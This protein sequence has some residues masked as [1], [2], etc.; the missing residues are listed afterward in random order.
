MSKNTDIYK[1]RLIEEAILLKT[2]SH[3]NIVQFKTMQ[4]TSDGRDVV[5]ME[6]CTI[7]LGDLLE[8]RMEN[9]LSSLEVGKVIKVSF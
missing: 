7:S 5:A 6:M 8:Q 1:R 3:P 9:G 4:K 2:L